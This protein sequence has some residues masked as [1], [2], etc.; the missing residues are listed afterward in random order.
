M[1]V[2]IGAKVRI[3]VYK[4]Q[5][6]AIAAQVLVECAEHPRC[7]I[8]EVGDRPSVYDQPADPR[9]RPADKTPHGFREVRGIRV[10]EVRAQMKDQQARPGLDAG[11][12]GSRLPLTTGFLGQDRHMRPIAVTYVPE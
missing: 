5:N 9:R 3:D 7:R 6:H 1:A 10:E 11:N 12:R 4:Y 2:E 8:V